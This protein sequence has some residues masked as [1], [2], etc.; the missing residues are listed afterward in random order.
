VISARA[1]S[2][3]CNSPGITGGSQDLILVAVRSTSANGRN[4]RGSASWLTSG[5]SR[6]SAPPVARASSQRSAKSRAG[7]RR[8]V[9]TMPTS[10]P[11]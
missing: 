5:H 4:Q 7:A 10:E 6:A 3:V 8:A 2:S 1:Y 9:S 11:L